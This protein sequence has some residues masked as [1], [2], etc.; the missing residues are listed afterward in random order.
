MIPPLEDEIDEEEEM[1]EEGM[2]PLEDEKP[3]SPEGKGI[4][5]VEDDFPLEEV[6]VAVEEEK[7]E[8]ENRVDESEKE[9]DKK[10]V[11]GC[12]PPAEEVEQYKETPEQE[13]KSSAAA[14][15]KAKDGEA[16]S[17][18]KEENPLLPTDKSANPHEA[19]EKE[20][21]PVSTAKEEG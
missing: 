18:H 14:D 15:S 8:M 5:P 4:P 13:L 3:Q 6:M 12:T 10:V 7:P 1:M 20:S 21:V 9:A 2:A 19:Q 17:T 16:P 11:D